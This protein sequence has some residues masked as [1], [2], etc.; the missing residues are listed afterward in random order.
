MLIFDIH[1]E[2]SQVV[3]KLADRDNVVA[4]KLSSKTA[5]EWAGLMIAAAEVADRNLHD[6]LHGRPVRLTG[7]T[8]CCRLVD[9][10]LPNTGVISVC[11]DRNDPS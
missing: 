9:D 6:M 3:L 10:V 5:I 8:I 2:A 4:L 7:Y 1:A 11:G